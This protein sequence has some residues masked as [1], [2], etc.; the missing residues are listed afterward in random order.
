MF[1]TP[2]RTPQFK[3]QCSYT[4]GRFN[5]VTGNNYNRNYTDLFA[6]TE[7]DVVLDKFIE[8]NANDEQLPKKFK[9]L[10][11]SRIDS[12]IDEKS[13]YGL[14]DDFYL[15]ITL[16]KLAAPADICLDL[17]TGPIACEYL[18]SNHGQKEEVINSF[19]FE[20]I[21]S[22]PEEFAGAMDEAFLLI[23]QDSIKNLF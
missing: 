18:Y 2:I 9:H 23:T 3:S 22:I 11:N 16:Q 4:Q 21:L 6:S 19:P 10:I 7:G 8:K 17:H 5:P 13:P 1:Q 15:N 12:L 20:F 14:S